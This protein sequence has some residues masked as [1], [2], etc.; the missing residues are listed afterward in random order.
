MAV[1]REL[2]KLHEE[3]VRGT[4]AELAE[5]YASDPPRGEVALVV[6]GAPLAQDE[7]GRVSRS[8]GTL[9]GGSSRVDYAASCDGG[10]GR[11]SVASRAESVRS[12]AAD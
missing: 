5:R 4:A 1:C 9:K 2:T 7:I 6:G 3:I 12:P 10:A 8:G 11:R